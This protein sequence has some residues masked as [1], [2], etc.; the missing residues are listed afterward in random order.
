MI[1]DSLLLFGGEHRVF[2]R[3]L[4]V[5]DEVNCPLT[6]RGPGLRTHE[7]GHGKKAIALKRCNLFIGEQSGHT[8]SVRRHEGLARSRWQ[9]TN[10]PSDNIVNDVLTVGEWG[11]PRLFALV[12]SCSMLPT[13]WWAMQ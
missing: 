13:S 5:V 4:P 6:N 8:L 7:V 12:T 1:G 9:V 2:A 11:K 3:W 10:M